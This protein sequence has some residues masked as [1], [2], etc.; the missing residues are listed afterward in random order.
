LRAC[1]ERPFCEAARHFRRAAHAGNED[2]M[3]N[4]ASLF[5]NGLGERADPREAGG[6]Y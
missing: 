5:E 4:L 1:S 3:H 6:G 2:A